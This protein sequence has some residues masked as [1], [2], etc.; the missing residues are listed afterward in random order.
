VREEVGIYDDDFQR[1]LFVRDCSSC[2]IGF[3]GRL[4]FNMLNTCFTFQVTLQLS[5]VHV[6]S[7]LIAFASRAVQLA[8]IH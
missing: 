8:R 6:I 1:F 4:R 3:N 7:A 2:T 5:T